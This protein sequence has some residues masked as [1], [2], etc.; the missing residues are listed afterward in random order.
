MPA[1][2]ADKFK[3][4]IGNERARLRLQYYVIYA[5]L[6]FVALVMTVMN[7][8]TR[9]EA[10][11]T[12]AT[13]VFSG[14][15]I[16]NI[17]LH[18]LGKT[19]SAIAAGL[20]V[21]EIVGLFVFFIISGNPEGFSVI[22]IA[23]LPNFGLLLFRRKFGTLF[24]LGIF[25]ILIFFFWTPV[26]KELLRYDYNATFMVRFPVLYL[27]FFAIAF[28]LEVIREATYRELSKTRKEMDYAYTHD[29]L[30]GVYNRYG[31]CR[32]RDAV[33]AERKDVAFA[34][35]DLDDF[36][37][38]N[39]TYGHPNGDVVLREIVDLAKGI[40]EG[41]GEICRWGGEEFI[42]LI[43]DAS[44]AVEICETILQA[45]RG[46]VFRFGEEQRVVTLSFGLVLSSA[47]SAPDPVKLLAQADACLYEAKQT[48]KDKLVVKRY[49]A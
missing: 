25:L 6:G 28:I 23:M 47:D 41:K 10:S 45:A 44:L 5:M 30:T 12:I 32:I 26:G 39:D 46:H 18:R 42:I 15:C 17:V 20:F 13:G 27:A 4:I 36:K 29:A 33:L 7:V 2:I 8:A 16:L 1:R 48:G 35:F 19:T 38:V 24:S 40:L 43:Y 9:K 3:N 22:W 49:A 34:L 37:S 11:L 21:A 14:A 31:F